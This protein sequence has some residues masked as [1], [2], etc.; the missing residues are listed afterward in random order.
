MEIIDKII[1]YLVEEKIS[2]T[3]VADALGKT[4]AVPDLMPLNRGQYRVGKIK[5]VYACEESNWTI[6]DQIKTVDEGQ[7]IFIDSFHCGDRA[8]IG[9]LV[10]KYLFAYCKTRAVIVRGKVRDAARLIQENWPIW[11]SGCSP[12]G[13]FK[14]KPVEDISDLLKTEYRAKYDGG[15]AICDDCGVVVIPKGKADI[16][17]LNTLYYVENQER[18]WFDRLDHYREN[19]YEIVCQKK[20]LTDKSYMEM[21]QRKMKS[22]N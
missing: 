20:Y 22:Q 1:D 16:N 21:H 14:E 9:E 11:C 10:S 8:L 12:I 17:L 15:I 18:I 2:T 3:E 6:H 5:W 13:C 19:T 7:I 4:G